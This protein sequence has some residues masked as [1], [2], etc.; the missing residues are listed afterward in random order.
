[1]WWCAV[2]NLHVSQLHSVD[3]AFILTLV[4]QGPGS[5]LPED[6]LGWQYYRQAYQTTKFYPSPSIFVSKINFTPKLNALRRR[7][8]NIVEIGEN[9]GSHPF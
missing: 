4:L 7:E 3:S 5:T 6:I 1:M 9:V 2:S 8:E